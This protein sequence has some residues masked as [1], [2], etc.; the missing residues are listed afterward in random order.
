[1]STTLYYASDVHGSEILW[2][3]FLGAAKYYDAEVLVM[4]GDITGKGIV[5]VVGDAAGYRV[6]QI[7]G[8]KLLTESE[9]PEVERRVRD[10]GL[11]PYRIRRQDLDGMYSDERAVGDVFARVMRDT[12]AEW[13]RLAEERLT[14]RGV[15]LYVMIGNDDDES[16]REVIEASP[17]AVDPEDRV[18][19]I[20]EGFSMFSCGWTNPTPWHTPREMPEDQLESHL[21]AHLVDLADPERAIFNFHAPPYGSGL[22]QAPV[23][24]ETLKPVVSGGAVT[25]AAVGSKAVRAVIERHRPALGLHGHIHE[26]RGIATIGPTICINTGSAYSEGV[27]HGAI[28]TLDR[29]KGVKQ[30]VLASG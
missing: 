18:V 25:V 15:R 10:L 7:T 21:E 4:G 11:Y 30:H 27:L 5:P 29:K 1:M 13:L 28:V 20:G 2:R 22:D 12:L 17:L 16:L 19:E 3:K 8:E 6:Q 26:S 14:G 24:D 9:L 23:L